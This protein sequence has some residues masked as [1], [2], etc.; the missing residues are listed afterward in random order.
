MEE[1][2]AGCVRGGGD[3]AHLGRQMQERVACESA[4]GQAQEG[5]QYV[6]GDRTAACAG[7]QQQAEDG[8]QAD[9]Q[10]GQGAVEVL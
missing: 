4:H 9:E 8:A 5:L 10:R 7:Q 3:R 2:G 6:V 1:L